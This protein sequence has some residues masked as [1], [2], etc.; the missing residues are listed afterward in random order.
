[1][2]K[3]QYFKGQADENGLILVSMYCGIE[4]D[5]VKLD[6]WKRSKSTTGIEKIVKLIQNEKWKWK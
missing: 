2:L 4:T 6:N 5:C 3:A 1:M